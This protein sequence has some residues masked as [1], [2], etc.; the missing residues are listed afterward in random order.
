MKTKGY[1]RTSK[2]SPSSQ[3]GIDLSSVTLVN[4]TKKLQKATQNTEI[5]T[6]PKVASLRM[7][8]G[9]HQRVDRQQQLTL[10]QSLSQTQKHTEKVNCFTSNP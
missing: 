7:K 8:W 1:E 2:R 5:C 10:L 4:S 3:L 9:G 6:I